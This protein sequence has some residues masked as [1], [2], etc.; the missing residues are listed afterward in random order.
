MAPIVT[1]DLSVALRRA[2]E[3]KLPITVRQILETDTDL[4]AVMVEFA[5]G[6]QGACLVPADMLTEDSIKISAAV[7]AAVWELLR[8]P[9]VYRKKGKTD[10]D[11]VIELDG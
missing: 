4:T 10:D 1:E 9:G 7:T 6:S 5:D 8:P 3:S 11:E 2:R